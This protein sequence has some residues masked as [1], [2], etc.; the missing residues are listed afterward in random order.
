MITV[1]SNPPLARDYH[2][3][4]NKNISKIGSTCAP[5]IENQWQE[6]VELPLIDLRGLTSNDEGERAK[7]AEEIVRASSEWGFF[8]VVNH[9]FSPKLLSQM[10]REQINLFNASFAKKSTF[11]LLNNSYRW[12]SP[13][14][15]ST[16]HFSWSEAFHIPLTK[17]S[18]QACY[19]EFAS[20]R[21]VLV[22]YAAAMQKLAKLLAE[23]LITNLGQKTEEFE[24]MV[25]CDES[26][27][28][29]RLNRYPACPLSQEMFG[30]VPHTDS[31]FLTI[32]HQDQ[33]GGL[34][35]MKDSKWVAVNPNK[36]ALIV[37]IGDLFQAWSNDL[38]KSVEHKVMANTK[39]ERFSVAYF[40]C[41]SYDSL[42][43][44]CK[45]PSLYRNFTFGEY[46]N[47]VQE[48]AKLIGHKVGLPRFRF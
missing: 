12:G 10:R 9:G 42:I 33:V 31:D 36:D 22:E 8:Q 41:P 14:A 40:L 48:D 16:Q 19:G 23:V 30:L 11:G 24:E 27:C 21:E 26:T 45:E 2:K 25:C 32:L 28:F 4:L 35:L 37:N 38:Y 29:L 1:E 34:Q 47:K 18:D 6:C 3:I 15:T 17:I 13:N 7:C 39:M 44:S 43:R 5:Q 20:L 46:R